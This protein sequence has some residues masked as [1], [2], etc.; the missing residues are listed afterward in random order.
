MLTAELLPSPSACLLVA[1]PVLCVGLPIRWVLRQEW[2]TLRQSLYFPVA[3][4]VR[5]EHQRQRARLLRRIGG[6][7][8]T[9]VTA[10]GR[11]VHC[12]WAPAEDGRVDGPVVLLLHANAMVL[13]DMVDWAVYYLQLRVS[14]MLVTFW[15]YPDPSE[16]FDQLPES[17]PQGGYCP[18]EATL[19]LD[20]EAA[21]SYVQQVHHVPSDRILAH[22][23][24]MG[25]A[26]ASA[27]GVNHQGIKVTVDQT[28]TSI[29]EVSVHVGRS[30]YDQIV[31]PRVPR[32]S[33]KLAV[34]LSPCVLRLAGMLIVRAL[35]KINDDPHCAKQDRLD[36]LRKAKLIRGDYFVFYSEH[37]E[38]MPRHFHQRLVTAR[39]GGS[40]SQDLAR[41]RILCVPG[42]HCA[43][44]A[45]SPEVAAQYRKYLHQI[46]FLE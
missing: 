8:T 25:G 38:M 4:Q 42:G 24:S 37:D 44:F 34:L 27:L 33:R 11:K 10:D 13:D 46:G 18:T 39:Y 7:E 23:V 45:D 29:F 15:G 6:V 35:F 36:N 21:L 17:L 22:G 3:G 14:V 40:G 28:F 30:L 9:V 31:L 32:W 1:L 20:A 16:E 5:F 2:P 12:V 41:T 19:Y 26:V 43:F